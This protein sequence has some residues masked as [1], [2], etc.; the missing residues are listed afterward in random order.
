MPPLHDTP[1]STNPFDRVTDLDAD[2]A[3]ENKTGAAGTADGISTA[4]I[5]TDHAGVGSESLP[6]HCDYT[7]LDIVSKSQNPSQ[8]NQYSQEFRWNH[9]GKRVDFVLGAFGF[10]QRIDT[11]GTEQQGADSAKWNLT[12]SSVTTPNGSTG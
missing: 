4:T 5:T 10:K 2:N 8:Q 3:A 7:G 11:Q 6:D 9:T 12:G 1:A